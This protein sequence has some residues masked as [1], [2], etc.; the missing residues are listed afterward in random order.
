MVKT[1][2][3]KTKKTLDKKKGKKTLKEMNAADIVG[4][5]GEGVAFCT[6]H[7]DDEQAAAES[8]QPIFAQSDGWEDITCDDHSTGIHTL[9]QVAGMEEGFQNNSMLESLIHKA[10][11]KGVNSAIAESS[12]PRVRKISRTQLAE[13]VRKALRIALKENAEMSEVSMGDF[14]DDD[15][16]DPDNDVMIATGGELGGRVKVSFAGKDIKLFRSQKDAEDAIKAQLGKTKTSPKVWQ[17]KQGGEYERLHMHEEQL[18]RGMKRCG[19]CMGS[20]KLVKDG[21]QVPCW[22]CEGQGFEK[23]VKEVGM[24][25][26]SM[27]TPGMAPGSPMSAPTSEASLDGVDSDHG[28]VTGGT[29]PSPEELQSALDELG[30]WDMD[31][32]GA[33]NLAFSYAMQVAGLE[34]SGFDM[35]TGHGMHQVLMALAN[36]PSPNELPDT[37][38]DEEIDD[39]HSYLNKVL[40]S[41]ENRY[42]RRGEK[43]EQHAE[44]LA[45]SILGVLGWEW[46]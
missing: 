9:G 2:D 20:G 16:P 34:S 38:S 13:G 24:P 45:S 30:G 7:M 18:P 35:N 22:A 33:D 39:P 6:E 8:L 21:K 40:D 3:K 15:Q 11:L 37:V 43:I 12:K 23:P 28:S 19:V 1:K 41:W 27:P 10:V 42:G 36:C 29:V 25:G 14:F 4:W 17:I 44:S 5:V 31:L 32:K 46:V 26:G